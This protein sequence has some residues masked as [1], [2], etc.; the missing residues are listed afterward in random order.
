MF[1]GFSSLAAPFTKSSETGLGITTESTALL[2]GI[3][4]V[5]FCINMNLL[6]QSDTI[7][8]YNLEGLFNSGILVSR[9]IK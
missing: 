1:F 3:R 4:Q 9:F 2:V 7:P 5:A 8:R 6:T